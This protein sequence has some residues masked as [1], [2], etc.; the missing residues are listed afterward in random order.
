MFRCVHFVKECTSVSSNNW[1]FLFG[2]SGLK[3]YW[4]PHVVHRLRNTA[5][6]QWTC[7]HMHWSLANDSPS[8]MR[9]VAGRQRCHRTLKREWVSCR[10]CLSAASWHPAGW[11]YSC[12]CIRG[13][14][15]NICMR[16][17]YVVGGCKRQ[18]HNF[19]CEG[20]Q[21]LKGNTRHVVRTSDDSLNWGDLMWRGLWLLAQKVK[22]HIDYYLKSGFQV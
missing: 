17:E 19:T 11:I 2:S 14:V 1:M 21:D 22:R 7:D 9:P 16:L 6:K 20:Q 18:I 10:W 5:L 8:F 3:T 12:R 13:E 4:T 15:W